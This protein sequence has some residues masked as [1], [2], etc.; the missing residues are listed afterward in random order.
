[1]NRLTPYRSVCRRRESFDLLAG[2]ARPAWQFGS[3][4]LERDDGVRDGTARG[5][6]QD[7][8]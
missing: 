1:M 7:A 3:A 6:V 5:G 8:Y 2:R 4:L